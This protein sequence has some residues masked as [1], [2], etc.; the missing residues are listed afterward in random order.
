MP[1]AGRP[2]QTTGQA[3]SGQRRLASRHSGLVVC[4]NQPA[5]LGRPVSSDDRHDSGHSARSSCAGRRESCGSH[6]RSRFPAVSRIPTSSRRSSPTRMWKGV[7]RKPPSSQPARHAPSRPCLQCLCCPALEGP[8][9]WAFW[10]RGPRLVPVN[11]RLVNARRYERKARIARSLALHHTQR[12]HGV[13]DCS[14]R[15]CPVT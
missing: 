10:A 3:C 7:S 11:E 1:D 4:S 14:Y 15:G 8:R 9:C 2:D 5:R 12:L 13:M 6:T